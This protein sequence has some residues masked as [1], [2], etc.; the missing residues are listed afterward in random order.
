MLNPKETWADKSGYD[1]TARDLAQRFE[2]NFKQFDDAVTDD[3][4]AA[5]IH[6]AA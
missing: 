2:A 3:V 1:S 6:A 5:G 4:K